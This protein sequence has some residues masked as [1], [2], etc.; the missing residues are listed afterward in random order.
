M[1]FD[2]GLELEDAVLKGLEAGRI[3]LQVDTVVHAVAGQNEC[4][5]EG[6]QHPLQPFVKAGARELSAGVSCFGEAGDSLAR[7]PEVDD[8]GVGE[9]RGG[10]QRG[11]D[12]GGPATVIG[13]AVAEER[14]AGVGR[15]NRMSGQ[16]ENQRDQKSFHSTKVTTE[17]ATWARR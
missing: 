12:Q 8:V 6:G 3:R 5:L 7:Q 15:T 17:N 9:L 11:L 10:A 13:D 1:L 4:G 2:G 14:D 16:G